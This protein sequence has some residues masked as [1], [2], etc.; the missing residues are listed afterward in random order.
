LL[1]YVDFSAGDA[2]RNARLLVLAGAIGS[3]AIAN[4]LESEAGV[5][6]AATAGILL[7]NMD[8]PYKDEIATFKGDVTLLVLSFVFITLAGILEVG[9]LTSVGLPGIAVVLAVALLIR[10]LLVFVSTIGDRFTLPERAFMSFVGPRGII[11]ASVATL[12]AIRLQAE[13]MG[14]EADILIGTVFLVI[15]ATAAVEGGLARHVAKY[16]DVIPMRVIIVGAGR[17]GR[18]LA[19]RLEDR[20]ENVVL[21]DNEEAKI[22]IARNAGYTAIL[23]DGTD[24]DV[25]RDAGAENAKTIVAAT[26]DDDVN[27]LVSQLADAEFDIENVIARVNKPDNVEP[28]EDLGV[29]TISASMATAWAIDNQIERPAIAHWMT[30]LGRIGDVQEVRLTNDT[31]VGESI[32]TIGPQLPESCLIALVKRGEKTFV[33]TADDTLEHGDMVTLLGDRDAVREGMDFCAG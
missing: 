31:L 29:R 19:E 16:L 28:F 27:L 9:A 1:R 15:L 33:P 4:F 21:V 26:S 23:G 7:G 18:A 24:M 14:P 25:L 5:A 8:V 10:P 2:P 13:G 6:A 11:P 17:V 12:F 32:E 22:E 20:G 30:D 3:F